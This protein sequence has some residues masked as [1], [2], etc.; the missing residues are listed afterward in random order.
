YDAWRF[1]Q[2]SPHLQTHWCRHLETNIPPFKRRPFPGESY[3]GTV[4]LALCRADDERRQRLAGQ[5]AE[6]SEEVQSPLLEG[7]ACRAVEGRG[8]AA[9]IAHGIQV[10][11]Q[12]QAF[13]SRQTQED[14]ETPADLSKEPGHEFSGVLDTALW[15]KV[16]PTP[17]NGMIDFSPTQLERLVA[18]PY[19]YYLQYILKV[20]AIEPND[21]EPSNMDFGTAIHAI[22]FEGFRMLQGN[23]PNPAIPGLVKLAKIHHPLFTPAWAVRDKQGHWHLQKTDVTPS[24][25]ALPLVNFP[26]D[27][28]AL[29]AF[30][31][32][33]TAAMLDWAT[34]GNAIWM[35]GAPE[36]LNVQ[37]RRISRAVRNLVRTALD[38]EALPEIP[39]CEGSQR[40]PALLEYTFND[41]V[42]GAAASLELTDP[43]NPD[44][45]L[46][47]HGKIDRVDFV[48]GADGL[49][50]AAIVVD[51]KGSTKDD[52]K[53][54]NLA[55]G[56]STAAD[57][58]LPAYALA[59]AR[60]FSP[61]QISNLKSEIPILMHYL[62]YTL[63][64]D[65]MVKQCQK[66]WIGLDGSPG[67]QTDLATAFTTSAFSALN[68]YERG[69]FAVAPQACEHCK[70]NAC[71][72][73]AASLLSTDSPE[74][75]GDS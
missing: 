64:P 60:A 1:S 72:R 18:C 51:Y 25:D 63:P 41:K 20:E 32:D 17:A 59:A 30:F 10:E 47:L 34:S 48:F 57:C 28:K 46:R 39:G 15:S 53:T 61:S 36:Q 14:Q 37:R 54:A 75:K 56:I 42:R 19:Q 8:L 38:P 69:D 11:R 4:P 5:G 9:Q 23:R 22:L 3:L 74:G 24:E 66:N 65:K 13:F 2:D 31:D 6:G 49:L 50:R 44:H 16:R 58:Q 70:L 35:L 7:E 33:L 45:R 26:S 62:S 71:C 55:E 52:L 27:T 12:R 73:H 68:R 40:Y 21:L 29:I 43:A 67:E